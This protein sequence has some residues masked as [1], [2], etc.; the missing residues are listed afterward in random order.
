MVH[1]SGSGSDQEPHAAHH[2][3]VR[4]VIVD[5]NGMAK[6]VAY[7]DRKTRQ[8]SRGLCQG[9]GAGGLLRR[10]G[11]HH[12]EFEV[13]AIGPPA[14]PTPADSLASNLCDHL[15]GCPGYG[16][17]PQLLGQPPCPDNIA[18]STVAWMPRWQNLKNP[19][20]EKFH[21]RL[22]D[23][24]G[25]RLR[26]FPRHYGQLEGFGNEYKRDIKRYYPDS[27]RRVIQAPYAPQSRPTSWTSIPT[28]KISSE[29]P[30][31]AFTFSG[32]KMNC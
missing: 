8:R 2:A 6:G 29:F 4:E 5:E 10:D 17:L 15:Y 22:L 18:D 23:L 20:E 25:R 30:S 26:R 19:H 9:G 27:G 16:Y 13:A 21:P 12:A 24:Y 32:D 11:A 28:R 14:L 31:S 7:I 3:L 1:D